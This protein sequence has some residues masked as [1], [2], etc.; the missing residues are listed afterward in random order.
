MTLSA[1]AS[2][3]ASS[4]AAGAMALTA[5]MNGY[6]G[7]KQLRGTGPRLPEHVPHLRPVLESA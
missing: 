2:A 6:Y 1:A 7:L 3:P 5:T 4:L